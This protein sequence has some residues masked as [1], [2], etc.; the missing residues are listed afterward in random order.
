MSTTKLR[1]GKVKARSNNAIL[2]RYYAAK[3]LEKQRNTAAWKLA[4]A[5]A[6]QRF[7]LIGKPTR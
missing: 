1:A 7:L 2:A 4:A 5:T 6:G 3:A